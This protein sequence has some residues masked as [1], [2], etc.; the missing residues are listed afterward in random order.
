MKFQKGYTFFILMGLLASCSGGGSGSAGS[1][2]GGSQSYISGVAA[3]GKPILGRVQV[4]YRD[5]DDN[6]QLGETYTDSNG[7]YTFN[8]TN[9]KGPYIIKVTSI[10]NPSVQFTSAATSEDIGGT[11]NITPL[12]HLVMANTVGDTDPSDIFDNYAMANVDSLIT[13]AKLNT[14]KEL[15][16]KAIKPIIKAVMATD[17]VD[18]MNQSFVANNRGL[19]AVLDNLSITMNHSGSTNG[20]I[21]VSPKDPTIQAKV[22]EF[23]DPTNAGAQSTELFVLDAGDPTD[24]ENDVQAIPLDTDSLDEA[25]TEYDAKVAAANSAQ[26]SLETLVNSTSNKRDDIEA[27]INRLAWSGSPSAQYDLLFDTESSNDAAFKNDGLDLTGFKNKIA[28]TTDLSAVQ[29]A[30]FTLSGL[31]DG[32]TPEAFIT[33]RLVKKVGGSEELSFWTTFDAVQAVDYDADAATAD[34]NVYPIDGNQSDISD[35]SLFVR[36]RNIISKDL[37]LSTASTSTKIIQGNLEVDSSAAADI[38]IVGPG[39]D[40]ASPVSI[41]SGSSESSKFDLPNDVTML[42]EKLIYKITQSGHTYKMMVPRP[43]AMSAKAYPSFS[44]SEAELCASIGSSTVGWSIPSGYKFIDASISLSTD[45]ESDNGSA[46]FYEAGSYSGAANPLADDALSFTDNIVDPLS[47]LHEVLRRT[48][49]LNMDSGNGEERSVLFECLGSNIPHISTNFLNHSGSEDSDITGMLISDDYDTLEASLIYSVVSQG[50]KG[51]VSFTGNNFTYTPNANANGS[52]SFIVSVTDNDGQVSQS[53]IN[54]SISALNDLPVGTL[55]DQSVD[56]DN[57]LPLTLSGSDVDGDALSYII[58]SDPASGAITCS[59]AICSYTPGQDFNGSDSF[60]YTVN[61][62]SGDSI[63]K[64]VT[65][66]VN[67]IN[68]AP[69]ANFA[70]IINTK[71]NTASASFTLTGSDVEGDALTFSASNGANGTVSCTGADCTYTPAASFVG[72]DTFSYTVSDGSLTS[73]SHTVNVEVFGTASQVA[74]SNL[75]DQLGAGESQTINFLVADINGSTVT[76]HNESVVVTLTEEGGATSNPTVT[77]ANGI[78]SFDI[79]PT[80]MGTFTIDFATVKSDSDS[81]AVNASESIVITSGAIASIDSFASPDIQA[82]A[83]EE[84]TI[85]VS[86]ADSF[87]NPTGHNDQD[88]LRFEFTSGG[89]NEIVSHNLLDATIESGV[90]RGRLPSASGGEIVVRGLDAGTLDYAFYKGEEAGALH[91]NSI[92]VVALAAIAQ[93]EITPSAATLSADDTLELTIVRQ[94]MYGNPITSGDSTITLS[95]AVTPYVNDLPNKVEITGDSYD[96][97]IGGPASVPDFVAGA[98]DFNGIES[99]V[100]L[101]GQSQVVVSGINLMRAVPSK[102]NVADSSDASVSSEL[103]FTVTA[104]VPA[105]L[106]VHP[107]IDV[108]YDENN[109]DLS[110]EKGNTFHAILQLVD[111]DQN[112]ITTNDEITVSLNAGDIV[113]SNLLEASDISGAGDLSMTGK[114]NSDQVYG[115]FSFKVDRIADL[116]ISAKLSDDSIIATDLA[117]AIKAAEKSRLLDFVLDNGSNELISTVRYNEKGQP[118]VFVDDQEEI[119]FMSYNDAGL[120]DRVTKY[121]AW[122]GRTTLVHLYKNEF[123]ELDKVISSGVNY[124]S[125]PS[126]ADLLGLISY[127]K[128]NDVSNDDYI[129]YFNSVLSFDTLATYNKYYNFTWESGVCNVID[130]NIVDEIDDS[131]FATYLRK[132]VLCPSA[133][134]GMRVA[135]IEERNINVTL[136][137][138]NLDATVAAFPTGTFFDQYYNDFFVMNYNASGHIEDVSFMMVGASDQ[139]SDVAHKDRATSASASTKLAFTYDGSNRL[140]SFNYSKMASVETFTSAFC[141]GSQVFYKYDGSE[142]SQLL[143]NDARTSWVELKYISGSTLEDVNSGYQYTTNDVTGN[144][145]SVDY[146]NATTGIC[147][148]SFYVKDIAS[149]SSLDDDSFDSGMLYINQALY[150]SAPD[151]NGDHAHVGRTTI[152]VPYA[153]ANLAYSSTRNYVMDL[154]VSNGNGASFFQ[155]VTRNYDA[156]TGLLVLDQAQLMHPVQTAGQYVYDFT[157]TFAISNGQVSSLALNEYYLDPND[158]PL[159][160]IEV[161]EAMRFDREVGPCSTDGLLYIELD[162]LDKICK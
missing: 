3:T 1:A 32:E 19:D 99:Q 45:R 20:E 52:D 86:A 29:V 4:K 150:A 16:R 44:N 138:E 2:A 127:I 59:G 17:S 149:C 61:D 35:L 100:I 140:A 72:Q 53:Q 15:V 51:T 78:G 83:G 88:V 8:V 102:I 54:I 85:S 81:T 79:S 96:F 118:R 155:K 10:E 49:E 24:L 146:Y 152:Y 11:V 60:G 46:G 145:G 115:A 90:L 70:S 14:N 28:N 77:Y 122:Y 91:T 116:A 22:Q 58:S 43:S 151:A 73:E 55:A 76:D 25:D 98:F 120:L 5:A 7:K 137:L 162:E 153:D 37:K 33:L 108:D 121:S 129:S 110:V 111:S 134:T 65:I 41:A 141:D 131:E 126:Q 34:I 109:G 13:K 38:S 71:E 144:C 94:D 57:S 117:I 80:A 27:T 87:T 130:A 74:I 75:P 104:G 30:N 69:V 47:G 23:K 157:D 50:L 143:A 31:G 156:T 139:G 66:T 67:P 62:G 135:T 68:D 154:E 64:V 42:P 136:D 159:N 82:D 12:T 89:R 133:S 6:V 123:G 148:N 18:I 93:F 147:I 84:I 97:Q 101:D 125:H 106:L 161:T 9:K 103:D 132:A 92:P 21:T 124:D 40:P 39:I 95:E 160:T 36:H 26:S 158:G 48:Y 113:G 56:E 142:Y 114:L 107:S 112:P 128:T 119:F 105:S 63:E